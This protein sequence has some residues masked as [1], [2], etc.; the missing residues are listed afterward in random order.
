MGSLLRNVASKGMDG[1]EDECS[2][3]GQVLAVVATLV[4]IL[5]AM[6]MGV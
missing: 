2:P 1:G 3:G 5:V 6:L 4:A